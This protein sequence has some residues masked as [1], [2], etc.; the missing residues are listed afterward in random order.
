MFTSFFVFLVVLSTTSWMIAL[1]AANVGKLSYTIPTPPAVTCA[2]AKAEP[3]FDT[4]TPA[5]QDCVYRRGNSTNLEQ[6]KS[7]DSMT[8]YCDYQLCG[9]QKGVF[10]GFNTTQVVKGRPRNVTMCNSK[11]VPPFKDHVLC[12]LV[13]QANCK[14][15]YQSAFLYK[16]DCQPKIA[17]QIGNITVLNM[18]AMICL[19]N[20]CSVPMVTDADKIANCQKY[21]RMAQ[22]NAGVGKPYLL[23]S[24]TGYESTFMPFYSV[25]AFQDDVAREL[26]TTSSEV[27]A[28]LIKPDVMFLG[29]AD[30]TDGT[31]ERDVKK[32]GESMPSALWTRNGI[33]S[34]SYVDSYDTSNCAAVITAPPLWTTPTTLPPAGPST[35]GGG[36]S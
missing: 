7:Y 19:Q 25:L 20:T 33:T 13:A 3:I 26:K 10:L 22:V 31:P 21:Q 4:D 18:L 2:D 6:V 29:F 35:P 8:A 14:W 28:F 16:F 32:V 1:D 23:L 17:E 11:P 15:P 27:L 9:C 34:V 12:E 36:G 5:D 30:K 24:V